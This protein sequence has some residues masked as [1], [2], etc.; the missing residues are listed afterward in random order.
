M[1]LPLKL[2]SSRFEKHKQQ[3]GAFQ[4]SCNGEFR[5]AVTIGCLP[6]I[7]SGGV[8]SNSLHT[9]AQ[10][11]LGRTREPVRLLT[12]MAKE[13]CRRTGPPQSNVAGWPT[14]G[15]IEAREERRGRLRERE[16]EKGGARKQRREGRE[17]EGEEGQEE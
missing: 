6:T 11:T 4:R 13:S 5:T 15:R 16:A 7:A 8:M 3:V 1:K 17:D 10:M 2:R 14:R 9:S 12:V